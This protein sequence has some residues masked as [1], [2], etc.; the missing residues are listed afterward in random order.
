MALKFNTATGQME[1]DNAAGPL[2][3][4]A[5]LDGKPPPDLSAVS[6]GPLP[7]DEPPVALPIPAP[8]PAP[9]PA[10]AAAPAFPVADVP[11]VTPATPPITKDSSTTTRSTTGV[12]VSP[13]MRAADKQVA[14]ADAQ[15]AK[16]LELE[17]RNRLA[18]AEI[19]KAKLEIEATQNRQQAEWTRQREIEA[20]R[21]KAEIDAQA[22][23]H[24][25]RYKAAAAAGDKGFWGD[26]AV[27]TKQA[28]A[29]SL[30]F[31]NIAEAFGAKNVGREL[32]DK[33]M[34]DWTAERDKKLGRLERDAAKS[35][36]I[37]QAFWEKWGPEYRARKELQDG[38]AYAAVADRW[39]AL[40]QKKGTLLTAAA[41]AE[42]AKGIADY[43][44]RAAEKRQAVVDS[45]ASRFAST[46][47]TVSTEQTGQTPAQ[48]AQADK[49]RQE[50]L[51]DLAGNYVGRA[52]R[53]DEGEKL[54]AGQAATNALHDS[55][56]RLQAF[57][58]KEGTVVVPGFEVTADKERDTLVATATGHLTTM[59]QT[60]VLQDKE[61]Q[62][63]QKMLK[64]SIVQSTKGAQENLGSLIDLTG[65]AY[66]RR[67]GSQGI[68]AEHLPRTAAGAA[69][70]AGQGGGVRKTFKLK[71][72]RTVTGTQLPNGDLQVD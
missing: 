44:Q 3:T 16:A 12:V 56:R 26:P 68:K 14:A 5:D 11:A 8:P 23:R 25:D 54:R 20:T 66:N 71:D 50:G 21:R 65:E 10:P 33:T 27:P 17:G 46:N 37:Q 43:R 41:L 24:Q 19:D 1:D 40:A 48:I 35:S 63:Y 59:F 42:N 72:G 70:A 36:G 30:M 28:W 34:H 39:E 45:R 38:A 62:R 55:L 9:A 51:F 4:V 60:G 22:T 31:G 69:P 32:L 58:A 13:E 52:R 64:P 53:P 29:L 57:T 2:A 15:G 49:E 7:E 18:Q 61:Y 67:V 47:T 6:P